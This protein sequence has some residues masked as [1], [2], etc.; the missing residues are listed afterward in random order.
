MLLRWIGRL[1]SWFLGWPAV[2]L[3]SLIVSVLFHLDTQLGRTL[4]RDLLNEYVTS[5]IDGRLHTGTIVQLRLWNTIVKN[6]YVFDPDG[7]PII[8]GETVQL[9]IDPLAALRG[10]LRFYYADLDSG[11]VHLIDDGEGS[12]TFIS[13][14]EP[15]DKTPSEP[16]AWYLKAFVEDMD[17]KHV[18]LYG[19]LLGL[20]GLRVEDMHV[21][22]RME[23]TE[24][25]EIEVWSATGNIVA[26]FPFEAKLKNLVGT[27]YTDTRGAQVLAEATRGDNAVAA[28]L[29]YRPPEGGTVDDPYDLDLFVR[30]EP[31]QADS[32]YEVGFDWAEALK[33]E[34][35]GWVRIWG[36]PEE[37]RMRADLTTA[38]GRVKA[39]GS[40]ASDG[41][42]KIELSSRGAKI[43]EF[44]NGV[45]DI[46][47]DGSVTFRTDPA[48]EELLYVDLKSQAFEYDGFVVPPLL[49]R[50]RLRPDGVDLFSVET[51]YA[52]G[53]LS[54]DGNVEFSGATHIH[55]YGVIP[56]VADDP[57]FQ[58]YAAGMRGSAQ[59]DVTIDQNMAGKFD[60]RGWVNINNLDYGAVAASL[61]RLKGHVWG[62]PSRPMLELTLRTAGLRVAGYTVGDGMAEVTGGPAQ[63]V[64]TGTFRA[65]DERRAEFEARVGADNGVYSLNVDS[66]E[67]A[68]GNRSWRG[69][70]QDAVLD[71]DLGFSFRRILMG[72]GAERL[73]ARGV[74]EFDGPDD[75]VADLKNF[76]LAVLQLLYPET[77]PEASGKVDLHFEF[78]GDLDRDPT[79]IAE[80]TLREAKLYDI[81]DITA[82]Y[83]IH[84][85]KS[86]LDADAQIRLGTRGNF[87]LSTTGTVDANGSDLQTALLEGIYETTFNAGGMDLRLLQKLQPAGFPEVTGAADVNVKLS[88][89]IDAPSFEGQITVPNLAIDD[90]SNLQARTEFRYEYGALS[91]RAI[92]G[93]ASG[94]LA[95]AEGS[96][97]V[98]LV[99]LV[100]SPKETISTLDVSPWRLS[101]RVPPRLLS[102]LPRR[103]TRKFPDAERIELAA[104][105]SLAGGAFK[106][107]GDLHASM[108]WKILDGTG[109]C[110]AAISP[111]ATLRAH[112]ENDQTLA[113][114]DVLIG[115]KRS[116]FA[117][118]SAPTPLDEWVVKAALPA[119]PVTELTA[120]LE[121]APT[122]N[123]PYL[124]TYAA[125]PMSADLEV[126]GLFGNS[127]ELHLSLD[128]DALRARRLEPAARLGT[129]TTIVETPPASSRI[130]LDYSKGLG[131][132][133]AQMEWWNGG[134][135]RIHAEVP[136]IWNRQHV[137]P[138]LS[139]RGEVQGLANFDRMPLQA[140]LAWMAGAVNVQG[141]L[142][143][144]VVAR[145]PAQK[146]NFSGSVVLSD[147]KVDLRT[148]GQTLED[149]AGRAI[150]DEDGV[151]IDGFTATDSNGKALVEGRTTLAGL[152]PE[153]LDFVIR[154]QNFPL[155]QEGIIKAR[156]DGDL[157]VIAKFLEEGMEGEV[158]IRD[159]DLNIPET[160]STPQ[161][162][163]S[164]PE[165]FFIDE[166]YELPAPQTYAMKFHLL[167][168]KP[169][170]VRS[171]DQGFATRASA[172]VWVTL[173]Q[174]MLVK[175]SIQLEQGYFEVFGKRFDLKSASMV[176][177]GDP[178]M[179][180]KVDLVATHRLRGSSDSVTVTV[181]GRFSDP[182]IE[183]TSTIPTETQGQVIA[184]L[185]TGTT[186]QERGVNTSAAD[187]S[188]QTTDFLTG[189][190]AGMFSGALRSE[191]G[192]LAPTFGVQSGTGQDTG[193][194]LQVGFNVDALIPADVQSV[195][196]GLYVEGQFVTRSGEGNRNTTGQAQRPGF[197]VEALWPLNFVT[198][199]TFAPPSNWSIDVTWEP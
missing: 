89:P 192:E 51:Q 28:E 133:D 65:R 97:L 120:K 78:R 163:A 122:E 148:V 87:S 166:E 153:A 145:G 117:R 74:W 11:W 151:A 50:T 110:G 23:F 168:Q 172:D 79:I 19:E 123:I 61:L 125:G 146:P 114:L 88:G 175:G 98:D 186:R 92:L 152:K 187:A 95:E 12:P 150:F 198:T 71:P 173:D 160:Q 115:G 128:A 8:Y 5:L 100:K 70:V 35:V 121:E 188:A 46:N 108:D 142:E 53:K 154:S 44:I 126:K 1:L 197:L 31:I 68:V 138:A 84:Y 107:Q 24:A 147:G 180:A 3:L 193:T 39:S 143:G 72:K 56:Q 157:R 124:C 182:T 32:L 181:S 75:I 9:G 16:G 18:T 20:Q 43:S 170:W 99:N 83:L 184:L 26:P 34:V 158:R 41:P 131:S 116:A 33:G 140:V 27:V 25:T 73:E 159:L 169:F 63:Y 136:L 195:V 6:T 82:A 90:W 178:D 109:L 162:L 54:L 118:A 37:Y 66:M 21:R 13:A 69:S 176:F 165:I 91:A 14:F 86:Q 67:V 129:V 94:E 55:A 42:T 85:E 104:S 76:D 190:A 106:T 7:T 58:R 144:S 17:L 113:E 30:A 15:A 40:L 191:F 2:L 93:D 183:F 132:A 111:H 22:G 134:S 49:A 177:D 52:G 45:P 60:T 161:E 167:S 105:L 102:A 29:V 96:L 164:H 137:M 64:A 10:R 103:F 199:G 179:D 171:R 189:V 57:N 155:R 135:T 80:G 47:F 149:V 62:D 127:P 185:V 139:P 196:R 119:L 174:E 36:P 112:I 130:E 156:M 141:I 81:P 59:F 38:G 101:A 77:A 48:H 4:G 194:Q